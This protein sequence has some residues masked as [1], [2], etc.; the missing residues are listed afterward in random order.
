M[1]AQERESLCTLLAEA[2]AL[3][4]LQVFEAFDCAQYELTA[5][6]RQRTTE[7]AMRRRPFR[8]SAARL[9]PLGVPLDRALSLSRSRSDV[10]VDESRE[11]HVR[12][13]ESL[14]RCSAKAHTVHALATALCTLLH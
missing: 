10:D 13:S 2:R 14:R 9:A 6:R 12:Q 4:V 11:S 5:Q 1:P 8:S 3:C 7:H